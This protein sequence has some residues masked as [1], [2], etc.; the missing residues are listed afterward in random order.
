MGGRKGKAVIVD[1][2]VCGVEVDNTV[3]N[4]TLSGLEVEY[5]GDPLCTDRLM[6]FQCFNCKFL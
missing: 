3:R 4:V 5:R 6:G 2:G 1:A